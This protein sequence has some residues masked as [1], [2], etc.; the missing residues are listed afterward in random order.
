M[1]TIKISSADGIG[2]ASSTLCLIHCLA[3]PFIFIAQACT[4]NCC[5]DTPIWWRAI[6]FFFLVISLIAV[7]FSAKTT[8]KKWM[9]VSFYS[10]F[11][12]LSIL[13]FNEHLILFQA[14]KAIMYISAGLLAGLHF[15]NR[16]C[17][18]CSNKCCHS[19]KHENKHKLLSPKLHYFK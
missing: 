2:M 3:T 1:Y 5:A 4:K 13:V 12:V 19:K 7:Y 8:P 9:Q 18:N 14:P 6:D 11:A 16:R 15:Y 10:L 17:V